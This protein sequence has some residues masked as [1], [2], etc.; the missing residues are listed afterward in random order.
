VQVLIVK[1]QEDRKDTSL[2]GKWSVTAH[3][4]YCWIYVFFVGEW[5]CGLP[6][7]PARKLNM[8]IVGPTKSIAFQDV[9]SHSL[10]KIFLAMSVWNSIC[11]HSM[12]RVI[13]ETSFWSPWHR[14]MLI[15]KKHYVIYSLR[16]CN[17]TDLIFNFFLLFNIEDTSGD[18][19]FYALHSVF[20]YRVWSRWVQFTCSE[21]A[22]GCNLVAH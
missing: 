17:W 9:K 5:L 10:V 15:C 18:S 1:W 16:Y 14:L 8:V 7:L 20:Y 13:S 6:I 3:N 4:K 19:L 12:Y 11:K 22:R 2:C 21:C